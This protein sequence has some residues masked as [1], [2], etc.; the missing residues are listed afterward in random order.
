MQCKNHTSF[1]FFEIFM[2][3]MIVNEI[4]RKQLFYIT[5]LKIKQS[6][7]LNNMIRNF[8]ENHTQQLGI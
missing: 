2:K 8:L 7:K 1:L 5:L 6:E 4:L 3:Q